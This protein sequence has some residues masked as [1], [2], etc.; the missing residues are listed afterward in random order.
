MKKYLIL[1]L[2]ALTGFLLSSCD[3]TST[4]PPAAGQGSV[5][6]QSTPPSAQIFVDGSNTSKVTPDSVTGLNEGTYSVKLSLTNY[7]DTTFTVNVTADF[8]T[9]KSVTLVSNL[10][11]KTY[12][13]TIWETTGTGANQ[14]SGLDLSAGVAKSSSNADIDIYYFSNSSTF[15]IRSST[16]RSTSFLV[17]TSSN[18][19]DGVS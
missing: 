12:S 11:T 14:P 4:N 7:R 10:T 8:Q 17:S 15:E 13:D 19:F 16:T 1:P 3:T 6:V 2:I 5:F 18:L 9:V